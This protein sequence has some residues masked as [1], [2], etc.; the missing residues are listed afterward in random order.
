ML[1]ILEGAYKLGKRININ[2]FCDEDDEVMLEAGE[3]YHSLL[4][5][6]FQIIEE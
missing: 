2:W 5:M 6:P 1:K 4:K 3:D